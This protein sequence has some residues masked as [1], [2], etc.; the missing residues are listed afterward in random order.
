MALLPSP[1][2]HLCSVVWSQT[3]ASAERRMQLDDEAF[4]KEIGHAFEH[5]LGDI[6]AVDQRFSF[7][8]AQQRIRQCAPHARV[9]LIGDAMRVVHPLAGQGVNLGFEDVQGVLDVAAEHRDLAAAGLWQRFA[10][11]R[12]TRSEIMLQIM[13]ALQKIYTNPHPVMALLRNIGVQSFDA[14]DGLKRQVMREAMGL[15]K[16]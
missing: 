13:S 11:A 2:E 6:L 12:Q 16:L 5:R 4:A 10:R 1:D 9:L 14:L 8:L 15:A 7:P 3:Q